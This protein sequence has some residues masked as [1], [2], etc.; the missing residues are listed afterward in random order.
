VT[1]LPLQVEGKIIGAMT[2]LAA[3]PEAF[4]PAEVELLSELGSDLSYG[5]ANLRT[6]VRHR[7][8]EATIKRLAFYDTLTG[9]PNRTLLMQELD[10]VLE[11]ARARNTP[12]EVL[13]LELGRFGEINR[14][15]GY[16]CGDQ[17]LL[18][19]VRRIGAV[20]PPRTIFARLGEAEFSVV[21]PGCA[22]DAIDQARD[23]IALMEEPI[24][25]AEGMID[26]RIGVGIAIFPGHG[27][28]AATLVRRAAAALHQSN[29]SYGGYAMHTGGLERDNHRR[30]RLIGDLHR[31]VRQHELQLFCQPKAEITSGAICG[32]EALIRWQHPEHG[33]IPPTD[34]IPLAEQ[35]GTITPV[36]HWIM[37][38]AFHQ[39]YLWHQAGLQLPMAVNL[40]AHDLYNP[41]LVDRVNGLF[42]TWGLPPEL[43]QFELTESALMAEPASALK[44]VCRLKDIGVQLFVDDFGTGYSGLSYLH[45]LP[46]DG[47]KIDQSFVMPMV[48]NSDSAVIVSSTIDLGHNLGLKVVAEGVE[49]EAILRR[50]AA[51]GC[52]VAQGYLIGKPMPSSILQEWK[53]SHQFGP[54]H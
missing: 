12:V 19:L 32:V 29:H 15:F 31:A 53:S 44:T 13:H 24:A 23:L 42:S 17:L 34:F 1:A 50:L 54:A 49:N 38:A 43:I 7:E 11:A 40:S 27:T 39:S 5:I 51:L 20:L 52:D 22:V 35:A 10:R 33:M 9:L 26:A 48:S 25:I 30:L 47:I 37:D 28:D 6:R 8:A 18:E 3:E 45:R 4:G 46:V 41:H 14:V 21:L 2:V 36:T 16:A